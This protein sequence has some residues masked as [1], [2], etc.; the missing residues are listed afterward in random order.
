LAAASLMLELACFL[1][2]SLALLTLL[3]E[4]HSRL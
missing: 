4:S 3:V 2:S 1:L